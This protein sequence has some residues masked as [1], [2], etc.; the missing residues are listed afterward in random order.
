M[1]KD[2]IH[3]GQT[4]TFHGGQLS[5][6]CSTG[7]GWALL[8]IEMQWGQSFPY[9][10]KFFFNWLYILIW[11]F[12]L[13]NDY[14]SPLQ[15]PLY[16]YPI[17]NTQNKELEYDFLRLTSLSVIGALV[18]VILR[19]L[20]QLGMFFLEH[21]RELC[22]IILEKKGRACDQLH[23]YTLCWTGGSRGWRKK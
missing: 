4:L 2:L 14:L 8:I 23:I 5:W 16:L 11:C 10:S 19:D 15:I 17:L 18:E 3:M 21:T 6:L 12:S 9:R 1:G 20:M 7:L 22:I 13:V